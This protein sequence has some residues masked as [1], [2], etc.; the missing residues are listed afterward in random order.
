MVWRR[1]FN[2]NRDASDPPNDDS[3]SVSGDHSSSM[4]QNPEV[5]RNSESTPSRLPRHVQ[6]Q[7]AR[8][9]QSSSR[10]AGPERRL[11]TL[12]R[13][14][15]GILYDIEQGMLAREEDNPWK[16]RAALLTESMETVDVDRKR[17]EQVEP[18]PWHPLPDTPI[19]GLE[20]TVAR[21][22][23]TV[24]FNVGTQQFFYEEPMDWA[25]RG[26]QIT[27]VELEHVQG[28][29]RPLVPTET[30]DHLRDGLEHH[31]ERSL[32]TFATELRERSLDDAAM[33]S[34]VVLADLA[35]PCLTCGGWTDY[36]GRC[37]RCAERTAQLQNLVRERDRLLNEQASELEEQHRIAERLPIAH[38]RLADID[39]EIAVM[40]EKHRSQP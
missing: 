18:G 24:R 13:R 2:R 6:D 40:E 35:R 31:L 19:T 36:L 15:Q 29:I 26:H 25:E 11:G 10:E 7:I 28:D 30:P 27:R 12:Q 22:I 5:S 39:I 17:L 34:P 4:E 21:D 16:Q 14:R 1:L 9:Q 33:P 32:F 20:V 23:A 38:R 37:Q 8:Q 3:S